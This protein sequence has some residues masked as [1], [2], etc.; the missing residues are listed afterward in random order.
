M[1][2]DGAVKLN[3]FLNFLRQLKRRHELAKIE[4]KRKTATTVNKWSTCGE[5]LQHVNIQRLAILLQET[6]LISV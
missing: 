4:K 6:F 5:K 1:F 2:T 3:S